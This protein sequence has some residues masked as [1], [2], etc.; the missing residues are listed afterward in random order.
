MDKEKNN[1]PD[2]MNKGKLTIP[3]N[4]VVFSCIDDKNKEIK[5]GADYETNNKD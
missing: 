5:Q 1:Q 3:P 2:W 4:L